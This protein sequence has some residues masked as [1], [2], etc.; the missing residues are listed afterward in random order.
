MTGYKEP[1]R[2]AR[3]EVRLKRANAYIL[4]LQR[5]RQQGCAEF[6]IPGSS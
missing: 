5:I 3:A 4:V 2:R 6:G 1:P